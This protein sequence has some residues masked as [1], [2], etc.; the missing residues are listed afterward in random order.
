MSNHTKNSLN[1]EKKKK[2]SQQVVDNSEKE[3]KIASIFGLSGAILEVKWATKRA[4]G[5]AG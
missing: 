2:G 4:R 5:P 3:L 1:I